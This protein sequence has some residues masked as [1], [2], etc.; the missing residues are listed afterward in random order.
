MALKNPLLPVT[1][2]STQAMPAPAADNLTGADIQRLQQSLDSSVSE[3]TR[4]MYSSAWRSFQAWAQG[5]GNLFLPASPQLVAAYLPHLAEDRGLS[6]ATIRLHKAAL[7]AVH[8]AAGH[9]D[10]TDHEGVRKVMKGIA[11]T[12]GRAQKQAKPLTAE[13]LAAVRATAS[14]RR[15]R[16]RRQEARIRPESLLARQGG[17]RP[18]LRSPGRPAPTLIA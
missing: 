14:T 15:P 2:P 3:N 4:K 18:P 1:N 5:R 7:A 8:K 11:R 13:A 16:G 9:D 12:H 10:P 6:V 17:S